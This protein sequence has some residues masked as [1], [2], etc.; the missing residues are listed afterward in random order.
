MFPLQKGGGLESTLW[1]DIIHIAWTVGGQL[2]DIQGTPLEHLEGGT[3]K[4]GA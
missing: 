1:P 2:N 4:F 3:Q